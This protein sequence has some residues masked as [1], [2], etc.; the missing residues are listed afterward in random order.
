MTERSRKDPDGVTEDGNESLRCV[1]GLV[2]STTVTALCES[3]DVTTSE[4]GL[5][6]LVFFVRVLNGDGAMEPIS[7]AKSLSFTE[8]I[9]DSVSK[10][11]RFSTVS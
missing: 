8:V 1:D 2:L 5:S 7:D 11:S 10:E 3:E 9:S 6:E 4:G